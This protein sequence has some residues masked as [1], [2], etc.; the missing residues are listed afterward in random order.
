MFYVCSNDY[1]NFL[2]GLSSSPEIKGVDILPRYK[3]NKEK[4]LWDIDQYILSKKP[5]C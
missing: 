1:D 2:K 5:F 4:Q 3:F